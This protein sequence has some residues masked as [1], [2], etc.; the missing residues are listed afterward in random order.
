MVTDE[1]GMSLRVWCFVR[2]GMVGSIETATYI[3]DKDLHRG[4]MDGRTDGRE[5]CS[6]PK[7]F[8]ERV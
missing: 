1:L 6:S 8:L 3:F 7:L 2:V 4:R 5:K